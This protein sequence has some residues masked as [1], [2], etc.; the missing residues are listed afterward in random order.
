MRLVERVR[1]DD[2]QIVAVTAPA[3]YGKSTFLRQWA[4][5]EERRVA[6]V[7]LET[8]DDDETMVLDYIA[9]ALERVGSLPAIPASPAPQARGAPRT[10]E[11]ARLAAAMWSVERPVVLMVD[12][13]DQLRSA[14]SVDALSWLSEHL[15]PAA[16]LAVASRARAPLPLARLRAHGRL[17]EVGA[18][19]LAISD[20]GARELLQQVGVHLAD[21]QVGEIT[22]RTE[23]WPAGIYM[24]GLSIRAGGEG[25]VVPTATA[26]PSDGH[27]VDG[28]TDRYIAD[29]LRT[30]LLDRLSPELLA[31]LTRTAP[32][33]RFD[34]SLC[35]HVLDATSSG[36]MLAEL[37][38]TNAFLVPLDTRSEQY[39]YHHL[40]RQLLV[41]ELRRRDPGDEVVIQRRAA[42][43]CAAHGDP[44]AA[45]EYAHLA[46]DDDLVASILL[47]HA[48]RV[49]RAGRLATLDR[50]FAWFDE[51]T[52]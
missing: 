42:E 6:W 27:G 30:E 50:W 36:D 14:A 4:E 41:T 23:G 20:D 49:H 5:L 11:L 2:R 15:P 35:D 12:D 25:Q 21:E 7:S 13:V 43:W 9:S 26:T 8:T 32:L 3:G 37:E 18:A 24:T 28:A 10:A 51:H 31:F 52:L 33:V 40:F 19:E 29:F 1:S 48:F 45:V 44:D 17:M 16:R 38:R 46:G 34:A 39:R 22:R 47:A